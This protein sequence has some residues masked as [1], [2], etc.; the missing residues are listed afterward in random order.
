VGNTL[1]N[2]CQRHFDEYDYTAALRDILETTTLADLLNQILR[3]PLSVVGTE[4]LARG[5]S[6][7]TEKGAGRVN[8]P[9]GSRVGHDLGR[10]ADCADGESPADDLAEAPDV[11]RHARPLGGPAHIQTEAGDA[12]G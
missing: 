3:S 7:V 8:G 5:G 12:R 11:R 9:G 4:E 6:G 10:A 2:D 1:V